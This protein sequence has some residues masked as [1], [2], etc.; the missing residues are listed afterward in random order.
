[1]LSSDPEYLNHQVE[2]RQNQI[3]AI[4]HLGM[5]SPK[6]PYQPFTSGVSTPPRW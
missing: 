5:V 3:N 4:L 6:V 2:S 1:M